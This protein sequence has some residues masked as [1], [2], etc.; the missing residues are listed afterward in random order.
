LLAY[1]VVKEQTGTKIKPK[2]SGVLGANCY[3][4]YTDSSSILSILKIYPVF[5]DLWIRDISIE[6]EL[7]NQSLWCS[8]RRNTRFLRETC[9]YMGLRPPESFSR[10]IWKP[11]T[12][13]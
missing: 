1:L 10:S 6:S 8:V 9:M 12:S 7:P 5:N 4:H 2:P 3:C 13:M 11:R